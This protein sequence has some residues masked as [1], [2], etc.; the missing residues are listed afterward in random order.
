MLCK[1]THSVRNRRQPRLSGRFRGNRVAALET[2]FRLPAARGALRRS[3][4]L[5][6][7]QLD[8]REFNFHRSCAGA[9]A[10]AAPLMG[11]LVVR[12]AVGG[13]G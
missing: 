7:T 3:R 12:L 10:R 9:S 6:V 4:A 11:R 1:C 13:L 2:R 5:N 8:L